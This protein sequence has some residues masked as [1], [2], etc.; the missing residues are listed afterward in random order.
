MTPT[1]PMSVRR[2]W[3]VLVAA[4][5]ATLVSVLMLSRSRPETSVAGLLDPS[6]P[7]V[8]ALGKVLDRF[9]V[10]EE[11]MLLARVPDDFHGDAHEVLLRFAEKFEGLSRSEPEAK[12]A[13]TAVR[14]RS[15]PDMR[16]FVTEVV[17]PHG[18]DY[19]DDASYAQLTSKL[20]RAAM[21]EQFA[22][23]RSM[24]SVPGAAA[25]E[26]A[27]AFIR[28]P[29]RLRD[30]LTAQLGKLAANGPSMTGDAFFSG[31]GR[32]LL[33][34]ISGTK[35]PS[36]LEFCRHVTNLAKR[37]AQQA[38]SSSEV[39]VDVA[40]AYAVAAH[41]V[42]AIRRD[43]IIGTIV[44]VG[45]IA[46]VFFALYRRPVR[47]FHFAFVPMAMGLV[48]GFGAYALLHPTF[49][50]LAAVVGGALGGVGIDYGVFFLAHYDRERRASGAATIQAASSTLLRLRWPLLA[51][52]ATS[53]V[54]FLSIA[55]SPVRVL[56]D[57][58]ILGTLALLGAYLACIT[59][60][61]AALSL[62]DARRQ[63]A[64]KAPVTVRLGALASVGEFI[65]RHPK[66][67]LSASLGVWIALSLTL[68]FSGGSLLPDSNLLSLHPQPN[69]PLDA[70]RRIAARMG[71]APG[72]AQ[73]YLTAGSAE[74]LLHTAHEVDRRLS[75]AKMKAAGMTGTFGIASLLPD[76]ETSRRR[77]AGVDPRLIEQA[78]RDL[79]AAAADAGFQTKPFEPSAN[80]L[81]TLL[82]PATP[83]P[84][85]ES[86]RKYP[87]VAQLLL[88]H[89]SIAGQEPRDA[90]VMV[91]F[92]NPLDRRGP[93]DAAVRALQETL[94]DMPGVVVTGMS[95][96]NDHVESAIY[97][98]L[99][100][101]ITFAIACIA[102]T[103]WLH[104]RSLGLA[105][106]AV[107]PTIV[108]ITVVLTFMRLM[109][110]PLD[111]VNMVMV[112]LLIGIDVDY[113][114]LTISAYRT[115]GSRAS[116]A[117]AFPT[118]A[119]AVATCVATTLV[120]FGSLVTTSVPA[121]RSLGILITVGVISC[122]T[123]SM[124]VLWPFLFLLSKRDDDSGAGADVGREDAELN[125]PPRVAE[126][127]AAE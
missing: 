58:A 96:I 92:D 70:Q 19:L 25:G 16:R 91:F 56:R 82:Q 24:L 50:P 30:L 68:V 86:L 18:L 61:P 84:G 81:K 104:F 100:K 71:I 121:V 62:F 46:A 63:K 107:L 85:L 77:R 65:G 37:L 67:I 21:D 43:S 8:V 109:S 93:R 42:D 99:P 79:L 112:P 90:M 108:S 45:A 83:P 115:A 28:D 26:M 36:D 15:S 66:T 2:S 49:T 31:D 72:T 122:L 110:L 20:T 114:I 120:G 78:P 54:G 52:W 89:T 106:L 38:G 126:T 95:A 74:E 33:I 51:A 103:L 101:L 113:S 32:S 57:F 76:P 98:D 118:T 123:A 13:I 105:L 10:V 73:L 11:L 127:R 94:S 53:V 64:E 102:L 55:F 34:R 116:L 124:T 14:Y 88:S 47:Q 7:A 6:D 22:Q 4:L 60:L 87:D 23:N 80:F 48:W 35:P 117:K 27:K 40:G 39:S 29:L 3:I 119:A 69:P 59:V 1:P 12:A 111:L 125:A 75:S 97:R 44:T 41:S 17:V 9:P 5:V